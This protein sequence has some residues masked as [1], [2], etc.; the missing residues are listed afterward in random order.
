MSK[1]F[2]ILLSLIPDCRV[3]AD[4]GCDHGYMSYEMLKNRKCDRVIVS[5]ISAECLKKAETLLQETFPDKFTAVVSDGFEN[6]GNCD[7]ALIAGMG[8][9]TISDILAA[10][11]G[12]LPEYLVLQPMKNSQRVRRDLVSLGYEILRDYTFRDGKFYDVILAKKGGNETYTAD[13]YAYGRDNLT[14]K[15]EDFIALVN[16]RIDE[17][18]EAKEK[19]SE[20]SRKEI[21]KRI[22]ELEKIIQ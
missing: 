21:E 22:T 18:K 8:G 10:A 12:R 5:D 7:C 11:A 2:N 16:S 17:L 13:D 15:G 6:V 20:T 4:V 3:F 1:R 14:E 9:D 19:A